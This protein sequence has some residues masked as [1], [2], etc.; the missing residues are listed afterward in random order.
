MF[1]GAFFLV[2]FSLLYL[3]FSFII[4][5][6]DILNMASAAAA[7]PNTSQIPNIYYIQAHGGGSGSL[8]F[9]QII[10]SFQEYEAESMSSS[11]AITQSFP[12]MARITRPGQSAVTSEDVDKDIV[13]KIVGLFLDPSFRETVRTYEGATRKSRRRGES[14]SLL[15]FRM[16]GE[17]LQNVSI[18]TSQMPLFNEFMEVEMRN[19]APNIDQNDSFGVHRLTRI[20]KDGELEWVNLS[21]GNK[22]HILT[23][24]TTGNALNL[25]ML[26][27]VRRV[28]ILNGNPNFIIIFPNCSPIT[29]VSFTDSVN[30]KVF[31]R[32]QTDSG[33]YRPYVNPTNQFKL[34]LEILDRIKAFY[35]GQQFF[36]SILQKETQQDLS[37]ALGTA[38]RMG[39]NIS[40]DLLQEDTYNQNDKEDRKYLIQLFYYILVDYPSWLQLNELQAFH[41]TELLQSVHFIIS[42]NEIP[43]YLNIPKFCTLLLI[44]LFTLPQPAGGIS[45]GFAHHIHEMLQNRFHLIVRG[46]LNASPEFSRKNNEAKQQ[47]AAKQINDLFLNVRQIERYLLQPG[48]QQNTRSDNFNILLQTCMLASSE[49]PKKSDNA[50]ATT[51]KR[52]GQKSKKKYTRKKIKKHKTY[53]NR[54]RNK[55]R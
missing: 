7:T 18:Y 42:P 5:S 50:T 45:P 34:L 4:K 10:K 9:S 48:Y 38:E 44:L 49:N 2:L 31:G 19:N 8:E 40:A 55:K 32:A 41:A 43:H 35:T 47:E 53:H 14:Q 6:G 30:R 17:V 26:E 21:K 13:K 37:R 33:V 15:G 1:F 25:P 39:S 20:N 28:M 22:L 11:P 16:A 54:T 46:R 29:D 27:I 52:G 23:D 3:C 51:S 24:P 12:I 36:H